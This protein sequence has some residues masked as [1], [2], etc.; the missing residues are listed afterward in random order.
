MKRILVFAV[1]CAC[2]FAFAIPQVMSAE[3]LL[4]VKITSVAQAKDKNGNGYTRAIIEESKELNGVKYTTGTPMM[5]FGD[6]ASK[7]SALKAGQ[8]V[9]V[10]ASKRMFNERLSYTAHAIVQ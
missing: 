3:E 6:M 9:K 7:G 8:T 5:F 4:T 10:I 2:L 1:I